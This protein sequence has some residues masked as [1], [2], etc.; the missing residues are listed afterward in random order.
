MNVFVLVMLFAISFV[1]VTEKKNSKHKKSGFLLL[2]L[3]AIYVGGNKDNNDIENYRRIFAGIETSIAP[4]YDLIN[5][6]AFLIG[7]SFEIFRLMFYMVLFLILY[8][9]IS[10][11]ALNVFY[12]LLMY[13]VFPM[14]FDSVQMRNFSVVVLVTFAFPYL[15]SGKKRDQ[16]IYTAIICIASA[17]HILAL[18]YL[19]LLLIRKVGKSKVAR[20]F[21]GMLILLILLLSID[22]SNISAVVQ[23][24]AFTDKMIKHSVALTNYGFLL[25]WLRHGLNVIISY[26]AYKIAYDLNSKSLRKNE[27][28]KYSYGVLMM[29]LILSIYM[30]LYVLEANYTRIMRNIAVINYISWSNSLILIKNRTKVMRNQKWIYFFF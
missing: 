22:K 15:L 10:K 6:Y 11:S 29:N 12:V 9:A 20:F 23:R 19:P 14:L 18:V 21:L 24:I 27:S 25:Y 2:I 5:N 3:L 30:P 28:L 7:M 16:L 17:F 1:Y 26:F 13:V 4:L 8:Y